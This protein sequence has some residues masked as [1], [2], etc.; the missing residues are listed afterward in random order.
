MDYTMGAD[1]CTDPLFHVGVIC[2]TLTRNL[3]RRFGD[4]RDE[5]ICAFEDVL[6]LEGAFVC[7]SFRR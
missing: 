6:A 1:L 4:V 7:I 5:I 2:G 3:A